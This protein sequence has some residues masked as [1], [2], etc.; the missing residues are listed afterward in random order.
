MRIGHNK[1]NLVE[2]PSE[3][4]SEYDHKPDGKPCHNRCV[5]LKI[6][7]SWTCFPPWRFNLALCDLTWLVVRIQ[8]LR[9]GRHQEL[10]VIS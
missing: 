5:R 2:S 6:V 8:M 7:H 10:H 3:N 4:N 1:V 9:S